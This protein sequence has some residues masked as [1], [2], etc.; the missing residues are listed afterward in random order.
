MSLGYSIL[1]SQLSINTNATVRVQKDIRIT[2][3]SNPT[4][5]NG[6][7]EV[8]NGKYTENSTTFF[9]D[10]DELNSTISYNV[11][12]TNSGSTNMKV[13][14]INI[15]VFNNDSMKYTFSNLA[16]GTVI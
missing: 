16:I 8:Y 5:T 10:L 15:D 1:S 2:A 12:I 11:T 4:A 3:I 13:S 9:V 7:F 6:G 14:K